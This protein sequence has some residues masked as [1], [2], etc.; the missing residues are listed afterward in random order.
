MHF[1]TTDGSNTSP[2][3]RV[4]NRSMSLDDLYRDRARC[5]RILASARAEDGHAW[6]ECNCP[7]SK[8]VI[9]CRQGVWHLARWPGDRIGHAANCPFRGIDPG[10]TG[11]A[12]FSESAIQES[13]DGVHLRI[14][15]SLT[16]DLGTRSKPG[17]GDHHRGGGSNRHRLTL[18]GLLEYLWEESRLNEYRSGSRLWWGRCH[19]ALVSQVENSFLGDQPLSEVMYVVPPFRKES[20]ANNE[21]TWNAFAAGLGS[22]N[23]RSR[24]GIVLGE[25]KDA[26]A[27]SRGYRIR[28]RNFRKPIFVTRKLWDTLT[29][30]FQSAFTS[31]M[32]AQGRQVGLWVVD[33]ATRGY[34]RLSTAGI[35]A[36][37]QSWI[38]VDSGYELTMANALADANRSFLKPLRY[39]HCDVVLPDFVITDTN[40]RTYIEVWGIVG[41][42]S[43]E[44]RK[45]EKQD[46]YKQRGLQLIEW[47]VSESIPEVPRLLSC[48]VSSR[49][50]T[51]DAVTS[52]S[53]QFVAGLSSSDSHGNEQFPQATPA[54]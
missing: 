15:T 45:Q 48:R 31:Q 11:R 1:G 32:T 17:L 8:L 39:Q 10:L 46:Y 23:R 51:E 36:T 38:P 43:Y 7:Q 22:K 6:C 50:S 24:L 47:N 29:M 18:L 25:F 3:V 54:L 21:A 27:T 2:N 5:A 13:R 26:A 30:R 37:T 49:L 41:R 9:R 35:M 40:P 44:R 52:S 19:H 20:A 42:E 34:L 28:L 14:A 16:T 53:G 33:K 4:G 12:A